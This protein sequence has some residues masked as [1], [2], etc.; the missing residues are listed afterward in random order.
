MTTALGDP[1]HKLAAEVRGVPKAAMLD[2]VKAVKNIADNEARRDVGSDGAMSHMGY[3][4]G[5]HRSVKLTLRDTLKVGSGQVSVKMT[6]G[7]VSGAW[8]LI[9]AGASSHEIGKTTTRGKRKGQTRLLSIGTGVVRGPVKHPGMR[10][11]G[12]FDRVVKRAQD[13]VP[14]AAELALARAIKSTMKGV[15]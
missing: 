3:R 12:T 13:E 2:A 4:Q 10:G 14:K 11:K 7:G 1:L 6:G 15:I 5:K 9:N 8:A